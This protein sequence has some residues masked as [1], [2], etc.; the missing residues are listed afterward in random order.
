MI[1]SKNPHGG[2][3]TQ[4]HAHP[5]TQRI[6]AQMVNV[7]IA[8]EESGAECE[9]NLPPLMPKLIFP[10][11]KSFVHCSRGEYRSRTFPQMAAAIAEQW[12]KYILD[13]LN[14]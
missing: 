4:A 10:N 8:C 11:P 1:T 2:E 7:L 12:G 14:R 5:H 9:G 3:R 13:D 6:T